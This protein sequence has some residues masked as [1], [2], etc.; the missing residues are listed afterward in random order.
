M[1]EASPLYFDLGNLIKKMK[2]PIGIHGDKG[3]EMS[4]IRMAARR[5]QKD[6]DEV[7][8]IIRIAFEEIAIS[9]QENSSDALA[10]AFLPLLAPDAPVLEESIEGGLGMTIW[11]NVTRLDFV[12]I[13]HRYKRA[14]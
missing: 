5:V 4:G 7:Q 14:T 10:E 12:L 1:L 6:V 11:L 8:S 9:A 13:L 3:K 2:T